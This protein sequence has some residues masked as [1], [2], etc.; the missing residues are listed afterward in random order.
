MFEPRHSRVCQAQ[1]GQPLGL[2]AQGPLSTN[3]YGPNNNEALFSRSSD[4]AET[5]ISSGIYSL[6]LQFYS[7]RYVVL[8]LL[9]LFSYFLIFFLILWIWCYTQWHS[10]FAS[11]LCSGVI[12]VKAWGP[13]ALP[14]AQMCA[15]QVPQLLYYFSSPQVLMIFLENTGDLKK[16]NFEYKKTDVRAG[17]GTKSV[18]DKP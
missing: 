3:S 7:K 12:P 4:P 17:E 18:M 15:R 6:L 9:V 5:S 14:R 10:R 13:W 11:S 16:K 1:K 8:Y 2:V